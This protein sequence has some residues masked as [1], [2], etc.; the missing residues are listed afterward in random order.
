MTPAH[1]KMVLEWTVARDDAEGLLRSLLD[2]KQ[3]SE[4]RLSD[5]CQSDPFKRATGRS[6]I[7]DAIASTQRMIETLNRNIRESRSF[8]EELE[9]EPVGQMPMR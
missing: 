3:E 1:Q 9:L 5:L 4:K 8:I 2:A 7:D 6:A